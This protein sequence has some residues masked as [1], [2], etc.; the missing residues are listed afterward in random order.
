MIVNSR[1]LS[2]AAALAILCLAPV[3]GVR[4]QGAASA[5]AAP[6]KIAVINVRNAIVA[7]T[8]GK[9]A[10]A[11]L[12]SQFAPKQSELQNLQKQIEDL[13][14]RMSDGARTLSD[15]E[16]AKLQREGELL[17]RRLQRG[18]DD[19]NEE[20]NAAQGEIVDGIGRKMLEVM[21]RY[22][23]ENGFVAVFDTSAQGSPVVYASSSSDITQEIV[24]LYDQAYPVKG[25][26]AAAPASPKPAAPAPAPAKKP[27][28]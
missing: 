11:Q 6:T 20:L 14:R 12:Q 18:N 13:Q 3:R 4:A 26:A 19:L 15:D 7:T 5:A 27:A 23:R 25:G 28:Q 21:D 9:Q 1:Y 8:E 10:Q 16:K 24:R 2:T 22:A 17:S